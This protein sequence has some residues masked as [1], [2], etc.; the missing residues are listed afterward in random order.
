MAD[1]DIGE[2]F[3]NFITPEELQSYCGMDLSHWFGEK[4]QAS[5]KY[6]TILMMGFK[7]SPYGSVKPM[8]FAKEVIQGD[9]ND[10]ENPFQWQRICMNLS[11]SQ[12]YISSKAWVSKVRSDSTLASD[13]A[14]YIDDVQT[15]GTGELACWKATQQFG[16][17]ISY[18]GVQD[19][20]QKWRPG[21]K[22]A[23]A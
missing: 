20:P 4:G 1:L 5:W 2:M 12:G 21:S 14:S 19:A 18:L 11:C 13:F 6:W 15:G 7:P 16:S 10:K 23:G 9:R 17:V 3:L 8:L 22:R